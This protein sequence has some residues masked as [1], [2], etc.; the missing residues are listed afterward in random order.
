M[1]WRQNYQNK[2]NFHA[3]LAM[4]FIENSLNLNQKLAHG[5]SEYENIVWATIRKNCPIGDDIL[6]CERNF[7][8]VKTKK[9]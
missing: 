7:L 2:L 1:S 5:I 8:M 6:S 4:D 3:Y 9:G